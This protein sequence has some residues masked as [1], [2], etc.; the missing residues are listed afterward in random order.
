MISPLIWNNNLRLHHRDWNIFLLLLMRD[1]WH[2]WNSTGCGLLHECGSTF[3]MYEELFE[4]ILVH[5]TTT[6][7]D[8]FE[9][10]SRFCMTLVWIWVNLHA[11]LSPT[12]LWIWLTAIIAWCHARNKIENSHPDSQFSSHRSLAKYF[13]NFKNPIMFQHYTRRLLQTQRDIRDIRGRALKE[14]VETLE[15]VLSIAVNV[16]N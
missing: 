1:R 12:V 3:N 10:R 7:H 16:S 6:S 13:S 14:T 5:D 8:I 11:Y 15:A 9:K 4:V 2:Q